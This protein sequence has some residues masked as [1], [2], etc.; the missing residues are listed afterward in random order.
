MTLKIF[1]LSGSGLATAFATGLELWPLRL[2]SSLEGDVKRLSPRGMNHSSLHS[3]IPSLASR[4][5][6]PELHCCSIEIGSVSQKCH[7]L[8]LRIP[9]QD[10]NKRCL[11]FWLA[12]SIVSL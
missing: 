1:C 4:N 7:F 8:L 6:V 5:F 9:E 10:Q 2:P 11:H 3:Y 12:S